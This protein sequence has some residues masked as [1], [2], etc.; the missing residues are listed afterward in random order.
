MVAT[1]VAGGIAA[2]AAVA[3]LTACAAQTSQ[4]G[5]G[6]TTANRPAYGTV[7]GRLVM[8][9]G[10]LGPGG[11]QPPTRPLS[12]FVQFIGPSGQV[13][14]VVKVGRSGSF[15]TTLV[16]GTYRVRG[17]SPAIVEVSNPGSKGAVRPCTVPKTVT[18]KDQGSVRVTLACVV[19]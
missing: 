19:P 13:V 14:Q 3:A 2:I 6:G 8:E 10:P 17:G 7:S 12:G 1:R 18:V 16:P 9:G 5:P 15:T 4:S 11:Q